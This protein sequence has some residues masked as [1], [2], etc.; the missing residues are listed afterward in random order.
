MTDVALSFLHQ[1][2]GEMVQGFFGSEA[3]SPLLPPETPQPGAIHHVAASWGPFPISLG[4]A[5]VFLCQLWPGIL[6]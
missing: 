6:G 4:L 1:E 2:M 5:T 3:L